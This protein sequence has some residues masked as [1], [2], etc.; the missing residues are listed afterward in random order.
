MRKKW[1]PRRAG[2]GASYYKVVSRTPRSSVGGLIFRFLLAVSDRTTVTRAH[3]QRSR[4]SISGME[5]EED[6]VEAQPSPAGPVSPPADQAAAVHA[7]P[8]KYVVPSDPRLMN[9]WFRDTGLATLDPALVFVLSSAADIHAAL[10]LPEAAAVPNLAAGATPPQSV[11]NLIAWLDGI[12]IDGPVVRSHYH[13]GSL[14]TVY[15]GIPEG[16]LHGMMQKLVTTQTIRHY[17]ACKNANVSAGWCWSIHANRGVVR[18]YHICLG[19]FVS[20]TS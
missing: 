3:F 2:A 9:Q 18:A 15:E 17:V 1:R 14:S 11:S 12:L 10:L 6:M 19:P 16:R 13:D 7:D 5:R 4:C 8:D 20:N